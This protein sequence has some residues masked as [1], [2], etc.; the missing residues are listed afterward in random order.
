MSISHDKALDL[1]TDRLDF[2][3]D[4][5]EQRELSGHLDWCHECSRYADM[6]E[7]DDTVLENAFD[8]KDVDYFGSNDEYGT[9]YVDDDGNIV[10]A[11]VPKGSTPSSG[12][13]MD[14]ALEDEDRE[15]S[16]AGGSRPGR[17]DAADDVEPDGPTRDRPQPEST[18]PDADEDLEP[19]ATSSMRSRGGSEDSE[20]NEDEGDDDEAEARGGA[21]DDE[22]VFPVVARAEPAEADDDESDEELDVRRG[23]Q[24]AEDEESD[25]GAASDEDRAAALAAVQA[26]A[27]AIAESMSDEELG[28]VD[29]A[30]QAEDSIFE[31]CAADGVEA[32]AERNG[33]PHGEAIHKHAEQTLRAQESLTPTPYGTVAVY[34]STK[35]FRRDRYSSYNNVEP[36]TSTSAAA[37][38]RNAILRSRTGR[39]GVEHHQ[40][41]GRLDSKGIHRIAERDLRLFKR[42]VTPDPGR[43]LVWVMPDV[44]GSMAGYPVSQVA[45]VSRAL[46]DAS[47]G[48][49]TVRMAV[50]AWSTPF[51]DEQ[52]YAGAVA[53]VAKIWETGAPTSTIFQLTKLKMGGTPDAAVLDWAW[54]Q[55]LKEVRPGETPV[56][57]M[58]SDGWGDGRL[59]QAIAAAAKH[60]VLVKNVALGN[61]VHEADQL[62]RF[63]RGN[64]VPWMGSIERTAR[65]LATMIAKMASGK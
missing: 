19:I 24:A 56:V 1:V 26:A 58:A 53:G 36:E 61:Y 20:S 22:D 51:L 28:D 55:I 49:P 35:G 60:G 45:T 31:T 59:P 48:T 6:I 57:I 11:S 9:Q 21:A 40:A 12:G 50:W 30:V 64:Y 16:G 63:G 54:K 33:A 10:V 42:Y 18:S 52:R 34:R 44:S 15:A 39:T 2:E 29:A 37:A 13:Q 5:S 27:E 25:E 38:I 46:A 8:W 3:L 62:A 43:F 17:E 7:F 41:R 14:L 23:R 32:A 47:S 65:P 4:P